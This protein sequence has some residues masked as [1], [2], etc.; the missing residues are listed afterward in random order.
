MKIQLL[1]P[2]VQVIGSEGRTYNRI[3]IASHYRLSSC[4][5]ITGQPASN[6][7]TNPNLLLVEIVCTDAQLTTILV[8]SRYND[9]IVHIEQANRNL[10][11]VVSGEEVTAL[12]RVLE[13]KG[14]N[15]TTSAALISSGRR[16]Q[17][18]ATSLANWCRTLPKG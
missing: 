13:T 11:G 9:G 8:D 2:W 16:R 4:Q 14:V 7:P 6:I 17:D 12:R 3:A 5:D 1:T 18:L 15:K 10:E